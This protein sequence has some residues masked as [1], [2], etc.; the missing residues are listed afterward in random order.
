VYH[1]PCAVFSKLLSFFDD[2]P[3]QFSGPSSGAY[4]VEQCITLPDAGSDKTG[5]IPGDSAEE[6][7]YCHTLADFQL[8]LRTTSFIK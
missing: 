8:H 3:Q 2:L 7:A 5:R 6:S 1:Q 4:H